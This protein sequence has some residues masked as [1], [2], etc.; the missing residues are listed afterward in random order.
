MGYYVA[1]NL[2][3]FKRAIWLLV[4]YGILYVLISPLPELDATMS[5]KSVLVLFVLVPY[6][7]PG[8]LVLTFPGLCPSS[9]YPVAHADVVDKTCVRLC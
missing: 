5:G 8:L 4:I 7:L 3:W 9:L 1:V 6:A 2:R